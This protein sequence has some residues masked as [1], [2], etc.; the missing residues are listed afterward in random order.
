MKSRCHRR[1]ATRD[2]IPITQPSQSCMRTPR[3]WVARP[4]FLQCASSSSEDHFRTFYSSPPRPHQSVGDVLIFGRIRHRLVSC[5]Q[6]AE[7]NFGSRSKRSECRRPGNLKM[8]SKNWAATSMAV[9]SVFD[10]I[11]RNFLE[12]RSTTVMMASNSFLVLERC[13]T[14]SIARDL[15][16]LLGGSEGSSS[17][18]G[19]ERLFLNCWKVTHSLQYLYMCRAFCFQWKPSSLAAVLDAENCTQTL[20]SWAM[21]N[22]SLTFLSRTQMRFSYNRRPSFISK[23]RRRYKNY[24]FCKWCKGSC[25][26]M[27]SEICRN[28]GSLL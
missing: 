21:C 28:D 19:F 4:D 2:D 18:N 10:G 11:K 16:P 6:D 27:V 1:S 3:E 13:I 26:C 17:S 12:N 9:S 5:H 22:K 8:S 14:K 23:H 20:A 7:V 24:L 25:L 15:H